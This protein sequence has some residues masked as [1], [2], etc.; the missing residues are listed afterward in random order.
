M[1][2]VGGAAGG[3]GEGAAGCNDKN[4]NPTIECGEQKQ[5]VQKKHPKPPQGAPNILSRPSGR[6]FR[7]VPR[8]HD[9][10]AVTK[11]LR[12]LA[13][14]GWEPLPLVTTKRFMFESA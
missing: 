10:G 12:N 11:E 13:E 3:E 4:K 14:Q 5:K 1:S 7:P 8:L 6:S 9:E 2:V